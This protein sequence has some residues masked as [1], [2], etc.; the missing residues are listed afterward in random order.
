M[1]AGVEDCGV[2]VS[3][4]AERKATLLR[5]QFMLPAKHVI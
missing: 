1:V 4:F 3:A 5:P 2:R